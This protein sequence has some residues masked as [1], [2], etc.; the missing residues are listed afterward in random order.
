MYWRQVV[1]QSPTSADA[2]QAIIDHYI[3]V[4]E[5]LN[6]R[7]LTGSSFSGNERNCCFLNTG[8][9]GIGKDQFAD[10]SAASG[11]NHIDDSRSIAVTDW[12]QDGDLDLWI[13]NRTSPRVRFLRNDTPSNNSYVAVQLEGLPSAKCPRDAYG[14]RVEVT[15]EDAS[16][17]SVQRTQTLHGGDSFLSQSFK[18]LHFGMQPDERIQSVAVRWPGTKNPESFS[19]VAAGKR[20][21]LTQSKA[22]AT[23]IPARK[24]TVSLDSA[25]LASVST[26]A[27]GR[28][29]I[30]WPRSVGDLE[31]LSFSGKKVIKKA[32]SDSPTL[33]L[34]WASWC[35][36]CLEEIK[37]VSAADLGDLDVYAL[38]IEQAT[39]GDGP[40]AREQLDI[41]NKAGFTGTAGIATR[42]LLGE[43]NQT[44]LE[45]IYLRT[46][47]PLPVSF[48]VDKDGLLRVVYKGLL[49]VDQLKKDLQTFDAK[50]RD[51]MA[52][53]VPFPGRWSEEHLDGNP[54]AV[55]RV[56]KQDG[57]PQDAEI[58]LKHYLDITKPADGADAAS[59]ADGKLDPQTK[60]LRAAT[61]YELAMMAFR[62]GRSDQG[63]AKCQQA[64]KLAPNSVPT[65]VAMITHLA[66]TE[67]FDLAQPY[68]K[69]AQKLAGDNPAVNFQ[70]GRV[71][72]GKKNYAAAVSHFGKAFQANPRMFSAGN[73]LAWILAT[74]PDEKV[75]DGRRA[76]EVAK[77]ICAATEY[78]D[79]RYY[80]TLA[81]AYAENGDFK[82][83][84]SITKKEIEMAEA[85]DDQ[86][87]LRSLNAQLKQFA[88]QKPI[89]E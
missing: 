8:A 9:Q 35:S 77:N 6:Q 27:T 17:Q 74:C 87:S 33:Y 14:A 57:A 25:P 22:V 39:S 48:L 13:T 75:R 41:L 10:V 16:G 30:S 66:N 63:F 46:D 45:S 60:L 31:Y 89:R 61:Y 78:K 32:V 67:Q 76:V 88:D 65:L 86:K 73:N 29:K 44:H 12:D 26:K 7:I 23:E 1:S 70:L 15:F 19:G 3:S 85:R 64:L 47:L 28:L 4:W 56:Y 34:C 62:S 52:L 40:T 37:E 51:A 5:P 18:W 53:S 59:T 71:G 72:L 43:L 69:L 50:G 54:I 36:P 21:R 83:A 20:W 80:G 58:F 24:T 55:A 11:L 79:H 68:C 84:I 82:N 38:N 81:A 42:K 2:D 49:D